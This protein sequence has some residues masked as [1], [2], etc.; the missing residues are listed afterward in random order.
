MN[1]SRTLGAL[2]VLACLSGCATP[3]R[4]VLLPDSTGKSTAIVVTGKASTLTLAE[5][6][7]EARVTE[8]KIEPARVDA[9]E[10]SRRYGAIL[11]ATPAPPTSFVVYFSAAE[12]D[13]A[14]ESVAT[15]REVQQTVLKRPAPEVVVIGH[16]DRVGKLEANDSLSVKR[17]L[18]V[19]DK[20]VETGVAADRIAAFGRGER[21]PLVAT[22][23][24]VAE[25]RN[26][27]VEIKVR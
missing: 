11:S 4:F 5:P 12:N 2:A 26:R 13:L 27:R 21:E 20:L 10:V 22:D 25:P 8:G 14:P 6:Y 7:A 3:E 18:F 9:A 23:D 16:T 24:E 19:R 15:L 17:A 1:A